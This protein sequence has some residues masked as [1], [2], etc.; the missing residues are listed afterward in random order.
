MNTNELDIIKNLI[1]DAESTVFFGGAGVSTASGIPDFRG[2]SGLYR[3]VSEYGAS[4]EEI[5]SHNY[6]S[7]DPET[8]YRYYRENM[9]YPDATPNG[10]HKALAELEARGMLSAVITQNIDGLHQA[11]GSEN[12]IELHGS[13]LRNYCVECGRSYTLSDILESYG[14]PRC[15]CCGGLVRPDVTLYGE[16]LDTNAFYAAENACIN[17]DVLIVGGTSLTVNPAASLVASYYGDH[18]II[19]NKSP[20][21]YDEF[22]EYVIRELI[23]DVLQYIVGAI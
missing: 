23:E 16:A 4:P 1:K 20:T 5:L 21:P 12:V 18:L 10:A 3:I 17:A 7:D 14:V 2:N 13:V 22:A 8:F 15:N 6:L 9:L 11:A 19:V